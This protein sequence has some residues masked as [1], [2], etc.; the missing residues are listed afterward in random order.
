MGCG[1][2]G[3]GGRRSV[4]LC[5]VVSPKAPPGTF[6]SDMISL[7][8]AAIIYGVFR[9]LATR[10]RGRSLW[11]SSNTSKSGWSRWSRASLE[12]R[13]GGRS[14]PSRSPRA[15]PSRWTR[16]GWF[17]LPHLRPQRLHGPPLQGG[18]RVYPGL[19]GVLEGRADPVRHHPRREQELPPDDP[20]EDT[21]RDGGDLRFGEF[22]VTAKL[23]GGDGPR[24]KGAPQDTW[25]RPASSAPRIHRRRGG[26]GH[27]SH[28][29][30]RARRHG[31]RGRS[32]SSL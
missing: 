10:V 12:G 18:Y 14:T 15:S 21:L 16:A 22:G 3:R 4:G 11:V 30:R 29:R 2:R 28:L 1:A 32:W 31:W 8:L 24:E 19:P 20:A 6:V 13:S 5:L 25:A 26:A 7:G 27:R 17:H 9:Y 23:T